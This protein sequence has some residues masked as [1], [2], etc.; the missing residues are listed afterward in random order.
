MSADP[1]KSQAIDH[2]AAASGCSDL[3]RSEKDYIDNMERTFAAVGDLYAKYWGEFFHFA[4]FEKGD[5]EWEEAFHRTHQ[6]YIEALRIEKAAKVLDLACGRGGFTDLLAQS[7]EG[8][9]LGID[10]S[11]SQLSHCRRFRRP[12]LRFKYHD[13]MKIDE[14]GETFD[15]IALL[16]ADCYLPDKELAVRKIASVMRPGGRLLLLSWCKKEGLSQVQEELVLHPLMRYWAIPSLATERKYRSHF[17]KSALKILDEASLNEKVGRNWE[18]GY[19]QALQGIQ[20][21]STGSAL[22]LLWK[23]IELGPDGLRLIKEQF[24]AAVYIKVGFDTGFLRYVY[25]LVEKELR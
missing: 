4:L 6:Q 20:N 3:A 13:I 12:N 15:A 1:H 19:E 23:G 11:R 17:A 9:V 21:L 10:I 14:L 2:E 22:R 8:S 25:F 24:P 18:F 7:T 5:E 16:D